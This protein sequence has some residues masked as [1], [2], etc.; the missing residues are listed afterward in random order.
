M[1]TAF[2]GAWLRKINRGKTEFTTGDDGSYG[3]YDIPGKPCRVFFLNTSDDPGKAGYQTVTGVISG[4][5][6][7]EVVLLSCV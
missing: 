3:F 1:T 2:W 4:M 6:T 7:D 5:L